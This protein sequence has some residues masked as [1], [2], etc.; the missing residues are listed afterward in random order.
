MKLIIMMGL[1]GYATGCAAH[2]TNLTGIVDSE[3]I[4]FDGQI[5]VKVTNAPNARVWVK[6]NKKQLKYIKR[7]DRIEFSVVTKKVVDESR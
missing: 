3:Q 5:A 4:Y 2:R 7:G 6:L 1:A